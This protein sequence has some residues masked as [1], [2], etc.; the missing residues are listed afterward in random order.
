MREQVAVVTGGT[1]GIGKA[2]ALRLAKEGAKVIILGTNE[3]LGEELL[4]QMGE[5]QGHS[6]YKGNVAKTGEMAEIVKKILEKY[7]KVDV[8]VNNAGITQDQLLMKM[9]E[10][11][12]DSVM[13]VNVK[14]CY[15]MCHALIRSM[16]RAKKGSIINIA[17]VV[18]LVGNPGQTNYAASKGAMIAFTKALAKEVA[19][20]GI[21]VNCIAPGYM[22]SAMTESLTDAQKESFLTQIPLG[23]V[24][25]PEEVAE[26][27]LFLAKAKYITGHVL[28]VDGGMS[29]Y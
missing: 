12:W 2:I 29:M 28:T 24:G 4:K 23:C 3:A 13:E 25:E 5:G 7:G 16:L 19:S 6:F 8:L 27:V 10:S 22:R 11:D 9:T 1:R 15:N 14:S 20:R 17:S 18:G 26:A 21:L